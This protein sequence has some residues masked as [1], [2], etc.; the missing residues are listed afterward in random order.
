MNGPADGFFAEGR[1][2]WVRFRERLAEQGVETS[3]ALRTLGEALE[4]LGLTEVVVL[5]L[6]V[7][8]ALS[9]SPLQ[10]ASRCVDAV[11]DCLDETQ[12][13][14]LATLGLALILADLLLPDE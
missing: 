8:R 12:R 2:R 13:D 1:G 5:A 9:L 7:A 3:E 10:A 11:S 4:T 14:F 6:R